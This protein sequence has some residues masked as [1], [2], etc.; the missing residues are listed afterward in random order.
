MLQE[1]HLVSFSSSS[2]RFKA[3]NQVRV[4]PGRDSISGIN[5]K[6]KQ[7]KTLGPGSYMTM[8]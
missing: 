6:L 2:P 8:D 4:L 5:F 1:E 3:Q 7:D